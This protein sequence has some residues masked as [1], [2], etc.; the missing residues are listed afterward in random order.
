MTT[1]ESHAVGFSI[2]T[3]GGYQASGTVNNH[4]IYL[5][6]NSKTTSAD[7]RN[8]GTVIGSEDGTSRLVVMGTYTDAITA[9]SFTVFPTLVLPSY[10]YY[11]VFQPIPAMNALQGFLLLTGTE[12]D[13]V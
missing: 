13:T 7:Q 11:A 5:H 3:K 9:E 12:D 6:N 4:K 10:T 2:R 1:P 8:K